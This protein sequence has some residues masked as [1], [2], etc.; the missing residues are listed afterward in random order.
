MVANA[1]VN[2]DQGSLPP[3]P[4]SNTPHSHTIEPTNQSTFPFRVEANRNFANKLWN[5]GRYLLGNLKG[6]GEAEVGALAVKGRMAEG[7]IAVR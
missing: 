1:C 2:D 4:P 6:L 7:D 3:A 5:A